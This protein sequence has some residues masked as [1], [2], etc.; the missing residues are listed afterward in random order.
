MSRFLANLY[1]IALQEAAGGTT[2]VVWAM[3]ESPGVACRSRSG[4]QGH[5]QEEEISR[6]FLKSLPV[7]HR[8][9]RG[10]VCNKPI[11]HGERKGVHVK[12]PHLSS[13]T[14]PPRGSSHSE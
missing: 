10:R 9:T 4:R 7:D 11:I 3:E 14:F 8:F 1:L 13:C 5:Q 12:R 2:L 6:P